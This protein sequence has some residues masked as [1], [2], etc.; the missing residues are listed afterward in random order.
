MDVWRIDLG[1]SSPRPAIRHGR[2]GAATPCT[3]ASASPPT[4]SGR[5]TIGAAAP[6]LELRDIVM[7]RDGRSLLDHVDLIVARHQRWLLLGANGSGKT[8]LLRIAALYEHP[9]GGQVR[10]AGAELG[11]SD[12]RV[13]RRRIGFVSAA[14]IDQLRPD[15]EVID[16]VMTAKH[17]ALE[18]WWHRYDDTDRR[19][20]L[21]C[22][23]QLGLGGFAGRRFGTLSSGER[24]RALLAR[25]L[26]TDPAVLLLDEPTSGLD[27]AGRE[28]L[29]ASLDALAA[30]PDAPPFVLVTHHLEDVPSSITHALVLAGGR[31]IASG[32][33][34]EVVTEEV[35]SRAFGM[36]VLVER[37]PNG[38]FSAWTES[39]PPAR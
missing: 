35:V 4:P 18:P 9:T 16:V 37:R 8:S 25:S 36:K 32:A 21:G 1:G 11:R 38:R 17:A 5:Q 19:R 6:V 3:V 30:A 22:L 15:L 33:A 2:L 29:L 27:L 28:E 20:A 7:R 26:M 31:A 23:D 14:M 34:A 24:T 39:P 13:L 10:V 12:V